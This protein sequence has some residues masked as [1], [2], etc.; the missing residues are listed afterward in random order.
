MPQYLLLP[1]HGC[2]A[3]TATV[4]WDGALRGLSPAAQQHLAQTQEAPAPGTAPPKWPQG[5][6]PQTPGGTNLGMDQL[7]HFSCPEVVLYGL[8]HNS[9]FHYFIFQCK[10]IEVLNAARNYKINLTYIFIV[11]QQYPVA[12]EVFKG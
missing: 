5:W 6:L 10:I 12:L 1:H 2:L 9:F 3:S 4:G 11:R 7:W 8:L